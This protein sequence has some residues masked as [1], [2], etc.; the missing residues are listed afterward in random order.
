VLDIYIL[1]L[2]GQIAVIFKTLV[3]GGHD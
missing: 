2:L 1:I 3:G